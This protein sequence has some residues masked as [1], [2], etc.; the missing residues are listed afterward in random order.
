MKSFISRMWNHLGFLGHTIEVLTRR[1]AC[2]F[3]TMSFRSLAFPPDISSSFFRD[4]ACRMFVRARETCVIVICLPSVSSSPSQ[5]LSLMR[6]HNAISSPRLSGHVEDE[7]KK[8]RK[9]F[10]N[11]RR[12]SIHTALMLLDASEIE[13]FISPFVTVGRC[14]RHRVSMTQN[15]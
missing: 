4:S 8:K 1:R 13:N 2:K 9:E 3:N 10:E 5:F 12:V 7:R 15:P 6:R 11:S 14:H